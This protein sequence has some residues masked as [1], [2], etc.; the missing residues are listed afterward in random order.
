MTL[1]VQKQFA[2]EMSCTAAILERGNEVAEGSMRR[3]LYFDL[4]RKVRKADRQNDGLKIEDGTPGLYFSKFIA[5]LVPSLNSAY[6]LLFLR[7]RTRH[8]WRRKSA[9]NFLQTS[10]TLDS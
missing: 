7:V 1:F 9:M 10:T 8:N 6:R 3:P 2:H 4:C 5:F